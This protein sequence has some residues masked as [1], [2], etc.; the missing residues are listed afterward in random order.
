MFIRSNENNWLVFMD[1]IVQFQTTLDSTRITFVATLDKSIYS[2]LDDFLSKCI[3]NLKDG[4]R[5]VISIPAETDIDEL[6]LRHGLR[7]IESHLARVH[8]SL[9]RRVVVAE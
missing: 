2:L 9:I 7:I 4:G 3:E 1:I 6:I 5:I 8:G